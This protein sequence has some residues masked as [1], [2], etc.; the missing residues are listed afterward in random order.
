MSTD[1]RRRLSVFSGC[2]IIV[3][4]LLG[5]LV[6]FVHWFILPP[7]RWFAGEESRNA[8]QKKFEESRILQ[9]E[10][11]GGFVENTQSAEYIPLSLPLPPPPPPP[12]QLPPAKETGS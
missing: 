10:A 12:P 2:G 11:A 5:I 9:Q 3:L 6:L 4:I 1:G 8:E 7:L